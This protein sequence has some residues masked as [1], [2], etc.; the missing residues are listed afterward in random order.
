MYVVI[1]LIAITVT[2]SHL[3]LL[4]GK[5]CPFLSKIELNPEQAN[6]SREMLSWLTIEIGATRTGSLW[7]SDRCGELPGSRILTLCAPGL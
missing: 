4:T 6:C 2:S 5:D 3:S 1:F 7:L